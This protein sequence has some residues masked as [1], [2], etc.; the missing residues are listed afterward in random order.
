[1][2]NVRVVKAVT[3]VLVAV[4][5]AEAAESN[6]NRVKFVSHARGVNPA[7]RVNLATPNKLA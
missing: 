1:V 2:K 5:V 6:A 3:A 4:G 7:N